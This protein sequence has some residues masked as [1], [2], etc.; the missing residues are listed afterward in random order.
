MKV[1]TGA[2]ATAAASGT[3]SRAGACNQ[4]KDSVIHSTIQVSI[5]Q[6]NSVR[7]TS[8]EA[9]LPL[10]EEQQIFLL[11]ALTST[12]TFFLSPIFHY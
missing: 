5:V 3:A 7:G 6:S 4:E 2:A 10:A 9:K 8:A 1:P 11:S 12:T